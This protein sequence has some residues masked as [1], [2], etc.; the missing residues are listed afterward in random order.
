M[1]T[2][3]PG[4]PQTAAKAVVA[5][6][7]SALSFII[8]LLLQVSVALPA[9]WPALIGALVAVLT[10]LGVYRVPNSSKTAVK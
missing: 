3:T 5:L 4:T 10:A 9:P 1:T 8:P 6:I 2:P 7:G